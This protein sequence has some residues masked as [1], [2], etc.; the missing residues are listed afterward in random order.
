MT[1]P[2]PQV[3]GATCYPNS[4]G[5]AQSEIGYRLLYCD[6]LW[7]TL[8]LHIC[9]RVL[10]HRTKVFNDCVRGFRSHT[11]MVMEF[12]SSVKVDFPDQ[13]ILTYVFGNTLFEEND[14]I[15]FNAAN[16]KEYITL[17]QARSLTGRIGRYLRNLG[18]GT[19]GRGKD[20][21]LCF[22][23][24]Q[25]LVGPTCFG[26]LCA[27]GVHSA[28]PMSS[29]V[30]E[31]SRQIGLS[32]P[33]VMIC[34]ELTRSTAQKALQQAGLSDSVHLLV[35][36]SSSCTFRN[37]VDGSSLPLE[38]LSWEPLTDPSV[39]DSTTALTLFSSGTTGVP[40]GTC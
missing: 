40:K 27:G 25:T 17:R 36:D 2:T 13:D 26:V 15:W 21:V 20:F 35:M 33:K 22:V 6:A 38:Q 31:V 24:N 32:K 16:T 5:F 11:V 8:L 23:E 34:S 28:C 14:P 10:C 37:T 30:A 39:L 4:Y 7:M 9:Q 29:T 1:C 18:V 19:N 3:L 12:T